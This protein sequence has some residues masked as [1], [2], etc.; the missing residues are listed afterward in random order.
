MK[1]YLN[2]VWIF[3]R[4]LKEFQTPSTKLG[5]MLHKFFSIFNLKKKT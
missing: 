5:K 4:I 2:V 1:K 3:F